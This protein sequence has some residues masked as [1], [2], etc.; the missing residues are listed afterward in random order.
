MLIRR[1]GS[2]A[3]IIL[4]GVAVYSLMGFILL[5]DWITIRPEW[6][7]LNWFH[8]AV[9]ARSLAYKGTVLLL[10]FMVLVIV[11]RT[12][13]FALHLLLSH[14]RSMNRLLAGTPDLTQYNIPP[15]VKKVLSYPV[16]IIHSENLSAFAEGWF[17]PRI[18]VSTGLLSTFEPEEL[19]AVM[20]HEQ[21]HC[22]HRDP[23]R[24]YMV[25]V[26]GRSLRCVPM[27][28]GLVDYYI[29]WDELC[30]D[31]YV[32]RHM[33]SPEGL[34]GVLLKWSASGRSEQPVIGAAAAAHFAPTAMN[35]RILQLLEPGRKLDVPL[36][37]LWKA[38][39]TAAG[40][41][42]LFMMSIDVCGL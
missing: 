11:A 4:I 29:I 22:R 13:W 28:Q 15:S 3:C 38:A 27:L 26:L 33:L 41:L 14:R 7:W 5:K 25:K 20:L 1:H 12:V 18:V 31:R 34:A 35:Y 16:T 8:E 24:L 30:A 32:L 36:L 39:A 42:F 17:R 19:K 9:Q 40:L 2:F 37:K 21:Y 10:Q 23:L 6:G